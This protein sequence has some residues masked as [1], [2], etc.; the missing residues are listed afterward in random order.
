MPLKLRFQ[1]IK[2]IVLISGLL[3]LFQ[4]ESF[5]KEYVKV[6]YL[7][8]NDHEYVFYADNE[9]Y[10]PYQLQVSLKN[11]ELLWISTNMPFYTKINAQEKGVYLFSIITWRN[12]SNYI[13]YFIKTAIGDPDAVPDTNYV[14]YLPYEEGAFYKVNQGY[15]ERFSHHGWIRYSL[16]FGLCTGTKVCAAR[17]GI[18]VDVKDDSDKGGMRS[19]YSNYAN[20]ITVYHKDGSFSQ[21]VHLK[22]NGSLVK[23]GDIVK[24]GQVIGYSGNTGRSKGPHLHFMVF[25]ATEMGRDTI[26]TYFLGPNNAAISLYRKRFYYSY[27]FDQSNTASSGLLTNQTL[28]VTISVN[29]NKKDTSDINQGGL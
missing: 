14:Y 29:T 22:K 4:I 16:D 5:S 3:F 28:K 10:C 26:P 13:N 6:Y 17:E 7:K 9:N 15:K 19:F 20:F 12:P 11:P 21:Y 24:K 23:V 2:K 27:R 18:V 1:L 8:A 25:R